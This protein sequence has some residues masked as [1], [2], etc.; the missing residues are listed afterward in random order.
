MRD[1][2]PVLRRRRWPLIVLLAVIA[3]LIGGASALIIQKL[4]ATPARAQSQLSQDV[5]ASVSPSPAWLSPD[6]T[7]PM[8]R[9]AFGS[10]ADQL[11]P[12]PI[13]ASIIKDRPDLF[14]MI[15]DNV[16]GDTKTSEMTELIEAYRRQAVQPELMEARKAMPF[17]ATWDDHDYGRNDAGAGFADKAK[18]AELFHAFW[19]SRPEPGRSEGIYYSRTIGPDGQRVQIIM[20]DT[21]S[22]KSEWVRSPTP[23][24]HWGRYGEDSTPANTIIGEAQW[25]WLEAELRKPAEIRLIVSSIQVLAEGHG[26]ERW[27]LF[28]RERARL[29]EA[30]KTTSARGVVLLSG[31]RHMGALYRRDGSTPYPLAELTSSSLNRSYGPAKDVIQPPI[32]SQPFHPENYGRIDIDWTARNV[33]LSLRDI[34][35]GEVASLALTFKDLGHSN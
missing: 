31:D 13:W 10:C 1:M 25:S 7:R 23:L 21:R 20:L 24:P 32:I 11:K 14:L 2:M 3:A 30:I 17:L 29:A 35:G 6:L 34:A 8:R 12:Q 28:P 15:G 4:I 26:F 22:F 18:A 9:I 33:T 27:G 5:L 19:R 16:Y